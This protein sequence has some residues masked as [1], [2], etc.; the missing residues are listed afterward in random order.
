MKEH[1]IRFLLKTIGVIISLRAC[2]VLIILVA[3]FWT[4]HN[5]LSQ[6]YSESSTAAILKVLMITILA[7]AIFAGYGLLFQK[8]WSRTFAVVMLGLDCFLRLGAYDLNFSL[9]LRTDSNLE[10]TI[11]DIL[12][13]TTRGTETILS[14]KFVYFDIFH[15]EPILVICMVIFLMT[16]PVREYYRLLGNEEQETS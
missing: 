12:K 5:S 2:M 13:R 7:C 15:I 3:S 16:K 11:F 9:W 4:P 6:L 14:G 1:Q 8:K 10:Q